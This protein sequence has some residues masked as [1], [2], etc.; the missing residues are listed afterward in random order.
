MKSF[1]YSNKT[2]LITGASSGIGLE[3]ARQIH[4]RGARV[5]LIARR[6]TLLREE[7]QKLNALRAA[8]AEYLKLDLTD[9]EDLIKA[10]E[11]VNSSKVDILVNNA[12][13]GSFGAFAELDLNRE[14]SQLRL[15]IESTVVLAHQAIRKMQIS[16]SGALI[17][18]SSVAAFQPL[19]FMATYSATKAFNY[20][21]STALREE[22]KD[23]GIR[24]L[25]VCPGPTATEFGGAA[26]VPGTMTGVP[27]DEVE[28]VVRES[29]KALDKN[30]PFVVTG[31]RSK[32]AAL[33]SVLL[34]ASI[35]SKII[36]MQFR[37]VIASAG[38]AVN[39]R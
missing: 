29:L 14:I 7:C 38:K 21:H 26:R 10:L 37:T 13:H 15:N 31:L 35:S 3:F 28:M 20:I 34:P 23:S 36:G 30:R 6:E 5:V 1:D 11:Y 27:R 18:V 9:S 39:I 25:T 17:S 32:F 22:L 33:F 19:P 4:S 16:G 12:G 8:S 24:V 2:A